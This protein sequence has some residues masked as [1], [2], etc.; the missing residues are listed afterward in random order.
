MSS[1]LR[2]GAI[3]AN[4]T[5]HDLAAFSDIP[6]LLPPPGIKPNFENPDG[7]NKTFFALTSILLL[8]A[9]ILI[10]NRIYVKIHIVR[11]YTLDDCKIIL[12][13]R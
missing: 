3:F 12:H 13:F 11:K 10:A 4:F 8:V 7:N 1:S 6:V 5:V 9:T 2:E